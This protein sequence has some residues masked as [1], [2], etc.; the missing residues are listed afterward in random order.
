MSRA[1]SK[2]TWTLILGLVAVAGCPSSQPSGGTTPTSTAAPELPPP[3]R[4]QLPEAGPAPRWALDE[5]A[6]WTM[7]NGLAVWHLR[8]A[9]TPLVSIRLVLSSG[10]ASDPPTKAG[11]SGLTVDM[12]DE[13]AGELS[14]LELNEALARLGTDYGVSSERDSVRLSMDMLADQLR[15][16]LRLLGDIVLRPQLP[17]DEMERRKKFWIAQALARQAQPNAVRDLI[18][19]RVLFGD[20]YAGPPVLGTQSSLANITLA[21]VQRYY[22]A[23]VLPA[24]ATLVAVGD[25]DRDELSAAIDEVFGSWQGSPSVETAK[26]TKPPLP[27]RAVYLVDFPGSTQSSIALARRAEGAAASDLFA[28]RVFNW[29]LG[30]AFSSRLNLNLREDKGYTYGA[31]SGLWRWRDAGALVLSAQ[32]KSDTTRPSL[33]EM[34]AELAALSGQRPLSEQEHREAVEGL[35]L[36]FPGRFETLGGI[37]E[38]LAAQAALGREPNWLHGWPQK[39]AAVTLAEASASAKRHVDVGAFAVIVVG[40]AA[41]VGPTLRSLDLPTYRCDREGRCRP[42]E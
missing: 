42:E 10:A 9:H 32:V 27:T 19:T 3:D 2:W 16:S 1:R 13:G 37:A 28:A 33:D 15:P 24:G 20:G 12:L 22:R 11:L 38:Q 30:G 34:H 5:V 25:V 39:I 6:H 8:Q 35:L 17:V 18:V 21:D 31:R 40:D 23:A 29:T 7:P 4:S 41:T 14:A 26:P 36:G